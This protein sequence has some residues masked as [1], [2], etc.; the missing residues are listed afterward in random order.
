MINYGTSRQ[1]HRDFISCLA[2]GLQSPTHHLQFCP[3]LVPA[4]PKMKSTGVEQEGC[5]NFVISTRSWILSFLWESYLIPPYFHW[6]LWKLEII[7]PCDE[8]SFSESL[9]STVGTVLSRE[10]GTWQGLQNRLSQK[11]KDEEQAD[12]SLCTGLSFEVFGVR[13]CMTPRG[14]LLT[15]AA[16]VHF[17][18]PIV[19]CRSA[20]LPGVVSWG[21]DTNLSPPSRHAL[22]SGKQTCF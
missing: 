12:V 1:A 13:C 17:E 3:S 4:E 15:G 18:R 10:A 9:V 20:L 11:T 8:E 5:G 16:W 14:L 2:E 19:I 21:S 6:P 22:P 7:A